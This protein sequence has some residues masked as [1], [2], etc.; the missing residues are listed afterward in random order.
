M[1]DT[2]ARDFLVTDATLVAAIGTFGGAPAIFVGNTVPP[3]FYDDRGSKPYIALADGDAGDYLDGDRDFF[4]WP[5]DVLVLM[6]D[7]GD[8]AP[9][10]AVA[11]RVRDLLDGAL[12]APSGYTNAGTVIESGPARDD[13]DDL[14]F[15]RRLRVNVGLIVNSPA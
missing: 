9:A 2:A 11:V 13:R 4:V 10:D 6:T 15:G 14:T 12:I 5:L 1:I 8:A 3:Q 7:K